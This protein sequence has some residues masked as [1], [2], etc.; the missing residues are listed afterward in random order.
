VGGVC[1]LASKT[2]AWPFSRKQRYWSN[3]LFYAYFNVWLEDLLQF[4][5][6]EMNPMQKETH[7]NVHVFPIKQKICV[8]SKYC[9]VCWWLFAYQGRRA[10]QVSVYECVCYYNCCHVNAV[11]GFWGVCLLLHV[12]PSLLTGNLLLYF[13]LLDITIG[14]LKTD[15]CSVRLVRI[16]AACWQH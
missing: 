8:I 15:F 6:R 3:V 14:Q 7:I 1:A 12:F 9:W 11:K 4:L 10:L 5:S 13:I 2:A 16:K